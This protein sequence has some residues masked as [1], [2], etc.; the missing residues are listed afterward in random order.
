[1][2]YI[3]YME[4]AHVASGGPLCGVRRR[5][6][7]LCVFTQ[8]CASQPKFLCVFMQ[9]YPVATSKIGFLLVIESPDHRA[10]SMYDVPFGSSGEKSEKIN[11]WGTTI[12]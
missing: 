2:S 6:N 12:I 7:F 10:F 11:I 9:F 4:K 5:P 3:I 8:F 1:M